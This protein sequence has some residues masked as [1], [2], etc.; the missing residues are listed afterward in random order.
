M[1]R[2]S[3]LKEDITMRRF[4]DYHL[5]S[6]VNTSAFLIGNGLNRYWHYSVS[7]KEKPKVDSWDGLL[8][9]LHKEYPRNEDKT[10][11]ITEMLR[12][13]DLTYTEA[14]DVTHLNST[15]K[16]STSFHGP[17]PYSRLKED[18]QAKVRDWI[19]GRYHKR[20]ANLFQSLNRPVLTL[21]Y[22]LLLE[23]SCNSIIQSVRER[24]KT[25][26]Y[27][28]Y[29]KKSFPPLGWK[30]N[31]VL[32]W[33]TYYSD[34]K[35]E[36]ALNEFAIWHIHGTQWYKRS[37]RLG[38]HDY[39]GWIT[40][41]KHWLHSGAKRNK[42][43]SFFESRE[44]W[45][46]YNTWIDVLLHTDIIIFGVG[47]PVSELTLRY[48]LLEREKFYRKHPEKR[49]SGW[50]IYNNK[51]DEM[52]PGK[53]YFLET[54]GIRTVKSNPVSTFSGAFYKKLLEISLKN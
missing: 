51:F 8:S 47:L 12:D 6:I 33:T 2:N 1:R 48:I 36:D 54:C 4:C 17:Q 3:N 10:V 22:D 18:V 7:D 19:P 49:K 23:C 14:F 11:D 16:D 13:Y 26:K 5:P 37:M 53:Q 42:P 30:G 31:D 41:A 32:P 29:N 40:K 52:N 38:L 24:N 21:N 28:K 50:Y 35:I 43:Y 44:N 27:P 20:W 34:H 39:T 15:N 9:D 46:G 45:I 25:K